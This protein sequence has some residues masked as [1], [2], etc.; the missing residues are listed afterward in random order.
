MEL[1]KR[2]YASQEAF[3]NERNRKLQ[4]ETKELRDELMQKN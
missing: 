3:L 2:S 1:L 4:A